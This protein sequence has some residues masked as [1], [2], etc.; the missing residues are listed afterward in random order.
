LNR[1]LNGLQRRP[2]PYSEQKNTLPLPGLEFQT[3]QPVVFII[4]IVIIL[5][6]AVF[7]NSALSNSS[8]P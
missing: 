4:V 7:R 6:M 8:I 3:V 5:I 1:R 2:G